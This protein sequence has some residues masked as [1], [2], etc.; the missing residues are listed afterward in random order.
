[1][2][3]T[4]G[5]VAP[6]DEISVIPGMAAVFLAA[7]ARNPRVLCSRVVKTHFHGKRPMYSLALGRYNFHLLTPDWKCDRRRLPEES[8]LWSLGEGE[9]VK[10]RV[11]RLDGKRV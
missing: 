11:S 10:W 8:G 1:M 4:A 2:L 5:F 6:V 7:M 9:M 3:M